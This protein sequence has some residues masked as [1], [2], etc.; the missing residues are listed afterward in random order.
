MEETSTGGDAMAYF[1]V[2]NALSRG[3]WTLALKPLLEHRLD[4][5]G[6]G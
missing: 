4:D 2:S 3:D 1:D 6:P 5:L